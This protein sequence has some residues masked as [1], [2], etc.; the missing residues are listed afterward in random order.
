MAKKKTITQSRLIT[1]YMDYVLTHNQA[2]KTVYAF[3]KDNNF[4]EADFYKNYASFEV[5]EQSIFK[6]FFDNTLKF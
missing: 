4:N 1:F 5:L 3:A 6:V 2:P